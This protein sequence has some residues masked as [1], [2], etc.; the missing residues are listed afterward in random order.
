MG[1]SNTFKNTNCASKILPLCFW[2]WRRSGGHFSQGKMWAHMYKQ[3]LSL[4]LTFA[5]F[6]SI[7]ATLDSLNPAKEING[8][9]PALEAYV[10]F[11]PC[12]PLNQ[13]FHGAALALLGTYRSARLALIYTR[14]LSRALRATHWRP[15]TPQSS[16]LQ[17]SPGPKKRQDW[18]DG[19]GSGTEI[20]LCRKLKNSINIGFFM[21]AGVTERDQSLSF[22]SLAFFTH[23]KL[24]GPM[25]LGQ[26]RQ[27]TI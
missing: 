23:R 27:T 9:P 8:P 11:I 16:G 1:K 19:S 25:I 10:S 2:G 18:T 5:M 26:Q 20:I 17:S 6:S 3:S 7:A 15:Q 21:N 24:C 12:S 13:I 14:A 22:T 4:L